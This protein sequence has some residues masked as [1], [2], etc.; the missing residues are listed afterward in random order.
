[1]PIFTV[2]WYME[3]DVPVGTIIGNTSMS[4]SCWGN[5]MSHPVDSSWYAY[6]W[7]CTSVCVLCVCVFKILW[8][9]SIVS[10][11]HGIVRLI[12]TSA[13]T[14]AFSSGLKLSTDL[15]GQPALY[16]ESKLHIM[17]FPHTSVYPRFGFNFE[18]LHIKIYPYC[19]T[20][21]CFITCGDPT[22]LY[23]CMDQND[24]HWYELII[25]SWLL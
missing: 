14:Y 3:F 19:F 4:L 10:M 24:I 21:K 17:S 11:T 12:Q 16:V 1:M 2:R 13:V 7:I 8:S 18:Y 6:T 20:L 5:F 22:L 25:W 23:H 9:G 15:Y